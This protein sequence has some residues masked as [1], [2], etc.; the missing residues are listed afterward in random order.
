MK[1]REYELETGKSPYPQPSKEDSKYA[2]AQLP[3]VAGKYRP[4][5]IHTA[6]CSRLPDNPDTM[7]CV[8]SAAVRD[9]GAY[10]TLNGVP[11]REGDVSLTCFSGKWESCRR[12]AYQ[13]YGFEVTDDGTHSQECEV[14]SW[15]AHGMLEGKRT[16][17]IKIHAQPHDLIYIIA[18][19]SGLC[20]H[21][22]PQTCW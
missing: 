19:G 2:D 7:M 17:C 22:N 13:T 12:L 10:I 1:D 3:M 5:D 8:S 20:G 21:G 6:S 14:P 4:I 11:A 9:K 16:G 15:L 18:D